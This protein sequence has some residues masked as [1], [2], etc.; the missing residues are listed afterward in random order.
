M[1]ETIH[2]VTHAIIMAAGT[3]TRLQPVTLTTPKPLVKVQGVRMIET[4]IQGLREY[5][6]TTIYVVVGYLKEQFGFLEQKYPGLTL[7]ENPFYD[8]CNNISSLFVAREHIG[9][10][11]ILDGDQIVRNPEILEPT[12]TRSG[13][14][15]VWSERPTDEWVLTVTDSIVTGCSRVGAPQGWQL[16]SVSRWSED[17]GLR[18]KG[19]I[20]VEFLEKKN[21]TIFWDDVALFCYPSEYTLGIREM[22]AGDIIEVD[23]FEELAE[24]DTSYKG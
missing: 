7:I 10:A 16:Y 22:K 14:N 19:H 4:I 24:L 23:T 18:L 5:S 15:C 3:G 1:G 2:R 9:G 6:I 12:F 21:T 17:D 20:E 11:I 13:Y 8:T